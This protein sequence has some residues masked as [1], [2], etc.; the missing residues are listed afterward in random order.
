V[1]PFDRMD[2]A[3]LRSDALANR[4]RVLAAA[5]AAMLREGRHVPMATIA[6]DA[7]V[8]VGTLYR[9]YPNREA[10]LDALTRRSFHVLLGIAEEAAAREGPALTAL[11]WWWDRV[12]DH[13]DQLV[14]PLH[15]GPEPDDEGAA[16]RARLHASL[17]RILEAGRRDGSVR[18]DVD[19]LDVVMFGAMLI[20][21]LPGPGSWAAT[22]R[23]QKA[24]F[25]DGLAAR[26]RTPLEPR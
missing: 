13:A 23:R 18:P 20:A 10:L 19:T 12:I 8:G 3:G 4:E 5:V 1:E 9:R 22:A 16:A 21:T 14:L 24:V 2:G 6:A 26:G 15:G 25:L 17:A 11:D 7:G